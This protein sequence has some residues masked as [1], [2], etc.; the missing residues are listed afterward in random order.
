MKKST[1]KKVIVTVVGHDSWSGPEVLF[2]K[3][4]TYEANAL[5]YCK[6]FNAKNNLPQTPEYYEKAHMPDSWFLT[7]RR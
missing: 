2:K 7:V 6:E 1:K 4:F 5:K 3:E